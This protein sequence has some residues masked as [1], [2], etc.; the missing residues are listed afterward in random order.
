MLT[1]LT[2]RNFKLF[3]EVVIEL[4]DRVVL[5]GP[6]NSGKTSALQAIALWE[7]G[8]KRWVEKRGSGNVPE[9]RPGVTINRKDLIAMPVP[10]ANL[11]WRDLHIQQ[12]AQKGGTQKIFIEVI[13]EGVSQ[14]KSWRCGLEFYYANEESLYCRS[15]RLSKTERMEV[16][17]EASELRIAYLPPMSGLAAIETRLDEGAINVRLGEG[18]TADVLRNLCWQ[19]LQ[20]SNGESK[21]NALGS[22]TKQVDQL[23]HR[24][25]GSGLMV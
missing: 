4:S 23:V 2:I 18:R 5:V 6:N 8:V 14:G 9:K 21:W 10:T 3:D 13:L 16:P 25:Q 24:G 22:V 15:L 19:V 12:A 7:I 11:L 1:K 20:S 17:T